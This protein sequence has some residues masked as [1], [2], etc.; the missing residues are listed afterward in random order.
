MIGPITK[1]MLAKFF[2]HGVQIALSTGRLFHFTKAV[3]EV[4]GGAGHYLCDEGAH[5]L[6]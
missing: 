6:P 5:S 4:L 2:S 3:A 1:A